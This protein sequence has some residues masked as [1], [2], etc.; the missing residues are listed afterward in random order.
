MDESRFGD[1]APGELVNSEGF[2]W[3]AFKP[4]S[5]PPEIDT[6]RVNETH[7][8]ARGNVGTLS[9]IGRRVNDPTVLITPFVYK[10]AVESSEIEGTKVTLSDVYQYEA[11]E[12]VPDEPEKDEIKEVRNYIEASFKGI[13][14]LDDGIDINLVKDLHGILLSDVRGEMKKPGD[15]RDHQVTIGSGPGSFVPP[16][17]ANVP[18]LMDELMTYIQTGGKYRSLIDIAIV[19]YQFE[20]IHPFNDG[21]GR[22]G[23][24]LIMLMMCEENLLPEPY[25]YPSSY[26][27]RNRDQ[28]TSKLLGV[29][30]RGEWEEW[31]KFFLEGISSQAEEAFS[32][33]SEFLDLRDEYQERYADS[34][35][36]ISKLALEIFNRPYITVNEAK[37]MLGVQ[38][39]TANR[40][41]D[42]LEED[43][44]L[45]EITGQDRN[46]IFRA[47]EVFDVVQK[48]T[49]ELEYM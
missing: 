30:Q 29:S 34:P 17:A 48:P 9:G 11:S 41:V 36:S 43:G 12:E 45:K 42:K 15:F 3:Q 7:A 4:D 24:L 47:R 14:R 20:T 10:E 38:Y 18:Y 44:V 31:I 37:E 6:K 39:P 46:R 33:G 19:H 35:N 1:N 22:M 16:P 27:N 13:K 21:N 26:F 2:E 28:Y 23:R 49:S 40:A 32:R 25:L 8:K 5:L